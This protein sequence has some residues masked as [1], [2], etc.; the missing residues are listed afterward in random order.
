MG[1]YANTD[2]KKAGMPILVLYKLDVTSENINRD[3][4]GHFMMMMWSVHQ[5]DIILSVYTTNNRFFKYMKLNKMTELQGETDKFTVV[6]FN[7]P[8]SI[9]D[10]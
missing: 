5:E 3:K 10:R 9:T 8:P 2:E 6:D 1:K 7:I 4:K